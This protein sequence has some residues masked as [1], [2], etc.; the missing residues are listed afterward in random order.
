MDVINVENR[1]NNA[2]ER[3]VRK[4]PNLSFIFTSSKL[5]SENMKL[6]LAKSIYGEKRAGCNQ[7]RRKRRIGQ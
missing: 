5:N 1:K 2:M 6:E 7:F 3:E 4:E